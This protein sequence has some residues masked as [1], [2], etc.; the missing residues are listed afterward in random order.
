MSHTQL[1]L[2]V[3]CLTP[4]SASTMLIFCPLPSQ[5]CHVSVRISPVCTAFTFIGISSGLIRGLCDAQEFCGIQRRKFYIPVG[6]T[7]V[8]PAIV[9]LGLYFAGVDVF[10][11]DMADV[12]LFLTIGNAKPPQHWIV[13]DEYWFSGFP[14]AGA[15]AIV[16]WKSDTNV[17]VFLR[18]LKGYK[19]NQVEADSQSELPR[20]IVLLEILLFIPLSVI[21][22]ILATMGDSSTETAVESSVAVAAL[23]LM[24]FVSAL[25]LIL[26]IEMS[27][28]GNER[29][30]KVIDA[31]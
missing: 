11:S 19:L 28:I 4:N 27:S 26:C 12:S 8:A 7:A 5:F 21:V 31:L 13:S 6:I 3:C 20:L 24:V 10:S 17:T 22:P 9:I 14:F 2:S 15:I 30:A 23:S 1:P 29:L 16:L 18:R 25:A